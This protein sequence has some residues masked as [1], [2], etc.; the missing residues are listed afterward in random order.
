MKTDHAKKTDTTAQS[1]A[2]VW[3][4]LGAVGVAAGLGAAAF[5]SRDT[6]PREADSAPG[7]TARRPRFG[8]FAVTGRTV[9]IRRDRREIY[10]FW[11]DFRNLA[12]FMEN[13]DQVE[14]LAADRVRWQIRAPL[15]QSV[16]VET[17]IVSDRPGEEIAWRSVESSEIETEGKVMFRDAP[18]GRGT[19]VE[20]IIA[21]RPP[22]GELGRLIGKLT[23]REPAAQ[24]RHELKRLKM[25]LETGE[26][27]TAANRKTPAKGNH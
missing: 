22:M 10:E 26:I 1:H 21:Y 13:V 18:G 12:R 3:I 17:R 15:G 5:A 23:G 20:A 8:K 4:A 27:A 2:R 19:E 9:T 7:R 11:R 25:L 16:G 24:G 14:E 6:V